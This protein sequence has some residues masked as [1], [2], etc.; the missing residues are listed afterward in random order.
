MP[1]PIPRPGLVIG[2]SYLWLAERRRGRIEGTKDRPCVIVLSASAVAQGVVVT[3]APITHTPQAAAAC[4]EIPAITKTRLGLD[5]D[6]S[7][8]VI[9]EVN[10]FLGPDPD[11]RPVARESGDRFEYGMLPPGLFR[12]IADR[13]VAHARAGRTAVVIREP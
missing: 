11:L 10:R 1:L 3:V 9:E 2:Y 6:R 7:W 8:V 4:A 13:L 12:Q 5:A